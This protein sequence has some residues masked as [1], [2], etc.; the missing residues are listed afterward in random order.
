MRCVLSWGVL[1]LPW[2]IL[3]SRHLALR[4]VLLLTR[5]LTRLRSILLLRGNLRLRS[6]LPLRLRSVLPLGHVLRPGCLRLRSLR[7][8]SVWLPWNLRLGSVLPLRLRC[9]RLRRVL[10]LSWDRLS[11]G[12]LHLF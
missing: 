4:G 1:C 7:R 6:V 11:C 12:D 3:L 2:N 5:H 9:L 10:R 8:R